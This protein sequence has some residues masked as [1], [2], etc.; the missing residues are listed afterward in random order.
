MS[1]GAYLFRK[2]SRTLT[3][4]HLPKGER[5][6]IAGAPAARFGPGVGFNNFRRCNFVLFFGLPKKSNLL[7]LGTI[8]K[9]RVLR[10]HFSF[11]SN[12]TA[13]HRPTDDSELYAFFFCAP[14]TRCAF[15][16][17]GLEEKKITPAPT[18]KLK[19]VWKEKETPYPAQ[20]QPPSLFLYFACANETDSAAYGDKSPNGHD[21]QSCRLR[22]LC[23]RQ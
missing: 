5:R 19:L 16:S 6:S 20:R 2:V 18:Q 17:L 7:I 12:G 23:I 14:C 13:D 10:L 22:C 9:N 3:H 1:I 8:P 4:R 15:R 11:F 21:G